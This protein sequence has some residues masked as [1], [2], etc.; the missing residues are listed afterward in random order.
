MTFCP[1]WSITIRLSANAMRLTFICGLSIKGLG[2]ILYLSLKSVIC[3]VNI[4]E[5]RAIESIHPNKCSQVK[6]IT[7]C[8]KSDFTRVD[9]ANSACCLILILLFVPF[10]YSVCF[11]FET[12]CFVRSGIRPIINFSKTY[13]TVLD[14]SVYTS[15]WFYHPETSG[16]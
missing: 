13:S 14:T 9:F 15:V 16:R 5:S 2:F 6:F 4:S 12:T 3:I 10:P 1:F 7:F 8:L 11:G